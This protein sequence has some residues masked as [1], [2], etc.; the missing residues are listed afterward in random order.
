[1][2]QSMF[3]ADVIDQAR[4]TGLPE[5]PAGRMK[6]DPDVMIRI[7]LPDVV[8]SPYSC[9]VAFARSDGEKQRD[10]LLALVAETETWKN[11]WAFQC[12]AIVDCMSQ[13]QRLAVSLA[14]DTLLEHLN[15]PVAT[16]PAVL[17]DT[18]RRCKGVFAVTETTYHESWERLCQPCYEKVT[19]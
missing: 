19:T 18:C 15:E 11:P 3:P 12:R 7:P 5:A 1:M 4:A 14:L 10:F 8:Q 6:P 9:G 2:T 17:Q 13:E 16:A